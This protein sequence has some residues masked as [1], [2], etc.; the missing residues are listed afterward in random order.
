MDGSNCCES[1][2]FPLWFHSVFFQTWNLLQALL[3]RVSRSLRIGRSLQLSKVRLNSLSNIFCFPVALEPPPGLEAHRSH[4]YARFSQFEQTNKENYV[5]QPPP[6]LCR[7]NAH[8]TN[9][10]NSTIE[11]TRNRKLPTHKRPS[12]VAADSTSPYSS[13]CGKQRWHRVFRRRRRRVERA[14]ALGF[15]HT[16]LC[17]RA[18][19]QTT[20][21]RW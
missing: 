12:S 2:W 19:C 6:G 9:F 3:H 11:T 13:F 10:R 1:F 18:V 16:V 20:H 8:K 5:V 7:L 15:A 21:E 4:Q 17:R 14:R